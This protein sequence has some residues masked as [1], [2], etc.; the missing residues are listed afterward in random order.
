M[1]SA[2]GIAVG[3]LMAWAASGVLRALLYDVSATDAAVFAAAAAR[4]GR[5]D[6]G[7]LSGP[8]RARLA[9]ASRSRRSGP[10]RRYR[11]GAAAAAPPAQCALSTEAGAVQELLRVGA[12]TLVETGMVRH[13]PSRDGTRRV[14]GSRKNCSAMSLPYATTDGGR[15][16]PHFA[17]RAVTAAGRPSPRFWAMP[18][19]NLRLHGERLAP[20][21]PEKTGLRA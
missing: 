21:A 10:S 16:P 20:A 15:D 5:R 14:Q 13:R 9:R 18:A 4:P 8:G 2:A 3:A 12:P 7:R 19:L 11:P 1:M 17:G 6:A